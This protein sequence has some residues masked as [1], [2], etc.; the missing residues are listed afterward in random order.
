MGIVNLS[1]GIFILI[2][3][4]IVKK[5]NLSILVAGYNTASEEEKAKYDEKKMTKYIGNLLIISSSILIISGF[6]FSFY[7][8]PLSAVWV[9][10][11]IFILVI[12]TGLVYLNTGNRLKK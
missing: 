11:G 7:N 12:I 3:G 2:L 1:A 6:V 8:E 10:W 4:I 5:F 9:S